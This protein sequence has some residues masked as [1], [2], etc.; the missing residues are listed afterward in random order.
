[1]RR[2]RCID[3]LSEAV[4]ALQQQKKSR[5]VKPE[6]RTERTKDRSQFMESE[7]AELAA[8]AAPASAH[9]QA[10]LA[11]SKKGE[12]TTCSRAAALDRRVHSSFAAELSKQ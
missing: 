11:S 5:A 8:A 10:W 3:E 1:M 9:S 12:I 2:R 7:G 6:P 4:V